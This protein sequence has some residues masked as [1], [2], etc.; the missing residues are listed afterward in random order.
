MNEH[1]TDPP[2]NN[3][4]HGFMDGIK[5]TVLDTELTPLYGELVLGYHFDEPV[6][7]YPFELDVVISYQLSFSSFGMEFHVTNTMD[8]TPLPFYMG[9]HPYFVCTPYQAY[10]TLEECTQWNR[11][12]LNSNMNP[13]G[14]THL[15][16]KFDGTEP[17]G[18]TAT[19]PTFYDDEFKPRFATNPDCEVFSTFL[20][21]P[22]T[23]QM[24]ILVQD[25]SFPL[26]HVFT[27][28]EN[29]VAIE[30]MSGMADAYNNH[31]GLTVLSGGETWTGK[32]GV[33]VI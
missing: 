22:P 28:Y 6:P 7:G 14:V 18:G 12:E 24:V 26:V 27:G 13:T 33:A 25:K 11:V 32:V 29:A 31:D 21:D 9:W 19:N 4:I 1:S 16:T 2:L 20:Y 10:I 5:M 23:D 8:T 3:A 15:F 30:P 17:I